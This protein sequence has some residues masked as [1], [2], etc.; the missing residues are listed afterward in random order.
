MAGTGVGKFSSTAGNNTSNLTVNFAENMAPSNVNNAARELMGHMRDMYEQLGDGYFEFGDGD[1][2]YTVARS[3]AD[4]I[5][6]TSSSDISGIYFAGR[7]IRIT[8][9]GANVVEGTIASSS[10][11]STTQTVNLTG[12]SLASGT[13]TKV[14][15][16]IDTAAFG[17]RI[18]L[19]D[20][21]DTYI[22]APTDDTIDFYIGGAKDFIMTANTFTIGSGVAE[23]TSIVFDGNAQDFYVALDDSADDL[24]IGLGNTIGTTPIMSFDEN[25]DVVIHD[26]GLT[27]TTADNTDTL[28]LISTDADADAGPNLVLFRNSANPADN[29]LVGAIRF[30]GKDDGGNTTT[31]AQ[32]ISQIIDAGDGS[33]GSEDSSFR[34]QVF[35]N[36]AIRNI[37][38]IDG[39][40][41]GQGEIVFNSPNQDMNFVVESN[42]NANAFTVD[43][44]NDSVLVN[45]GSPSLRYFG[46]TS[47]VPGF[48]MFGT[49]N[50][51]GRTSAFTYGAADTGGHLMMFGKSRSATRDNYTIVQDGD[52][53]GRITFQGADGTN[54]VSCVQINATVDGTPG[55]GDMPGRLTFHTAVD[56]T[57]TL[58]E[59]MRIGNNGNVHIGGTDTSIALGVT[60]SDTRITT[61]IVFD[62]HHSKSDTT[63]SGVVSRFQSARNTTNETYEFIRAGISGV[64]NKFVV[65]DSGDV[66][67]ANSSY[68]GI[69]D[70]RVKQDIT[71]A[72]SQW[73]DIKALKFK[74]FKKKANVRDFGDDA[75][76][77]LGVIAQDLEASGM[78]GLIKESQ[79]DPSHIHSDSSFGTLWTADDPETQDFVLYT[80]DDE[81]VQEGNAQIGDIKKESSEIIG[82]VK[83][84]K[85]KVKTVK[86][87]VLY[88]KAVKALQEAMD[89]IE[90]LETKVN[91]LEG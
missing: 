13:P 43:S 66:D 40:T 68:G 72:N 47:F 70:E 7:K 23:D 28:T 16:G 50:T 59:R 63:F 15:L 10:H 90:T 67:N 79:P 64:A 39:G 89:R 9:G 61:G 69:S 65:H 46:G 17:G 34:L 42:S 2:E 32:F 74:N 20:D 30:D 86:Y 77:E 44:G 91:E 38:Q 73:N 87:S 33:G 25:K 37:F 76:K 36:G 81:E 19:D 55:S 80:A 60:V 29:D 12:I 48:E 78:S 58:H 11:T 57:S 4:T 6:I 88:M 1:G 85:A 26:G 41:S 53:L 3:D 56:G 5:T 31:Y 83:E 54:F 22:E 52:Q 51:T 62:V 35:N 71:D 21:G 24:V 18:I 27:I 45:R 14:E 84:V 82:E 8:D 49:S 75:L